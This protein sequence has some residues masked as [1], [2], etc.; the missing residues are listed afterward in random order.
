MELGSALLLLLRYL[1]PRRALL[2]RE[3]RDQKRSA[4]LSDPY[5]N[6]YLTF[7]NRGEALLYT[8]GHGS[9]QLR[10]LILPSCVLH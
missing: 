5:G 1:D 3:V 8:D 6:Y 10:L 4:P 2:L 7:T 9:R